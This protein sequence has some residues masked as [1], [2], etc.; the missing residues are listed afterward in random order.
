MNVVDNPHRIK[1]FCSLTIVNHEDCM[2]EI[3]LS[4]AENIY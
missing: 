4:D 2:T 1:R 3:P